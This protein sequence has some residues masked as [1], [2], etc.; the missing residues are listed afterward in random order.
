[1][2]G[3]ESIYICILTSRRIHTLVVKLYRAFY[4][5]IS[6]NENYPLTAYAC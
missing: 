4:M 5:K 2:L 1:M 6:A 3:M